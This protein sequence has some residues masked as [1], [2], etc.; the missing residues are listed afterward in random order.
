VGERQ[1]N[2][3]VIYLQSYLTMNGR[4]CLKGKKLFDEYKKISTQIILAIAI[5]SGTEFESFDDEAIKRDL[6]PESAL[7]KFSPDVVYIEGGIL[8]SENQWKLPEKIGSKLLERGTVIIIN[9]NDIGDFDLYKTQYLDIQ[10]FAKAHVE[11]ENPQD[12]R[13]VYGSDRGG[14]PAKLICYP[15][16]MIVSDWL[17]PI[18]LNVDK[19]IV[20]LPIKLRSF[21]SLIISGNQGST[22]TLSNDTWVDEGDCCP[23]G[24]VSQVGLGFVV[25]IAGSTTY[26]S[27][28]NKGNLTWLLNIGQLLFEES[29]RNVNRYNSQYCSNIESPAETS[30]ANEEQITG[31]RNEF[32]SSLRS[33]KSILRQRESEKGAKPAPSCFISYSW[34]VSEHEKWVLQLVKDLCNADIEVVFDRWH[35]IPGHSILKFIEKIEVV[36]FTL[37]VGTKSYLNKYKCESGDAV[38]DA[39]LRMIG[40]RLRKRA[41]VRETVLPLLL[42]GT[43]TSSFPPMFEDSV[44]INFTERER[45]FVELFR[46]LLRLHSIP[47][48]H[49]GLD[50]LIHSMEPNEWH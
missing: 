37:A 33:I 1:N 49:P 44:F 45:Y 17:E 50:E 31:Q 27:E 41:E 47:F 13:P 8:A 39:E 38:V 28:S 26:W 40:T 34:G 21:E 36:D 48:D 11:Y 42:E 43:Q 30:T 16:K 23:F 4:G 20:S 12:R 24:N 7:L 5:I 19:V 35:N 46:L 29:K 6:V 10:R 2:M 9:D 18:Y 22:G 3:N 15:E 25:F 32:E 14:S